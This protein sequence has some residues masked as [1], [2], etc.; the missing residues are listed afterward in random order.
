MTD[1]ILDMENLKFLQELLSDRFVELIN[2]Y[3]ADSQKRV[4]ALAQALTENDLE[5]AT[6]EAHGLKGSSRNIGANPL[7]DLCETM[8]HQARSGDIVDQQ[9]QLA[10]I[11]QNVAAVCTELKKF[12]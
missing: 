3:L 2:T 1:T 6:H 10:A 8:E 9:Q 11:E 12:L 7:A 4:E 5:T